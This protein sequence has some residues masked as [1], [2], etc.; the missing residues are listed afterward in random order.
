[1][2]M[3]ICISNKYFCVSVS[4]SFLKYIDCTCC[5]A[6]Q[7]LLSVAATWI[8]P[9][10][11]IKQMRS[12]LTLSYLIRS[13]SAQNTWSRRTQTRV[14]LQSLPSESSALFH[15]HSFHNQASETF[16][17]CHAADHH[18]DHH[19]RLFF[20]SSSSFFH[21]SILNIY[22][23]R[24]KSPSRLPSKQAAGVQAA[25]GISSKCWNAWMATSRIDVEICWIQVCGK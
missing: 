10:R 7:N 22:K 1:M 12:C 15:Q 8:S 9:S 13:W 19:L 3:E 16:Q 17:R 25:A 2:N 23:P 24:G 4:F 21:F 14:V 20:S 11:K 18:S 5:A 6:F